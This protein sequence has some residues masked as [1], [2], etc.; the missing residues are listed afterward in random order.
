MARE[1]RQRKPQVKHAPEAR[2]R[3]TASLVTSKNKPWQI[4]VVCI[5]LVLVTV[6]SFSGVR[7][8]DFVTLDD[9]T[10]VLQNRHVQQGLNMQSIAWAFTSFDAGNWHPLTWIS[11]MVDWK[12]YGNNPAGH[13]ITNLCLHAANAVLLFL[14]LLYMT[15]YLGRAAMVA[16]LFALHPAHVESVAWIAERKDVLCAFFFLCT[17]LAYA[18]HLRNPSWKR[19][20]LVV[21]G[22]ACALLSKPMAVTLPFTLL[23]LDYWPLRRITFAEETRAQWFISLFKLCREKWLLFIMA[24]VSSVITV[25]AQKSS[26]AV[27]SLEV[28]SMG[29]RICNAA[30]SYWR[31]VWMM[32]WPDQLRAYY[33][34]ESNNTMLAAAV[35]SAVAIILVT[36]IS[37]RLRKERP[38]CLF[39]WLWFLVTLVPVIGIVQVGVQAMAERYTYIPFIG[40]FIAVVW[41]V[42]DAVANSPKIRIATQVLAVALIIVCAIKTDAQVK[43]WKDSA[44][45][46]RHVLEIDPRGAFPNYSL[47]V[48]YENQGKSTEAQEYFERALVYDPNGPQ[49]LSYSAYYMMQTAMRTHDRSKLPLAGQ[50]LEHALQIAPNNPEILTAMALW[51][52]LMGRPQDEEAYSRKAIAANPDFIS[53]RL[54]LADALRGQDKLDEAVQVYRQ[55]LA[56]D[57][58]NIDAHNN[59]GMIYTGQ[60]LTDDALKEFRLSLA[61]KPNQALPHSKIGRILAEKHQFPEAVNEFT[62]ALRLDQ[63]NPHAHND[64][65][66]AL[67][68]MGDYEKAAEQ[69]SAAVRIDPSYANARQNLAFALSRMKNGD[70]ESL[71]K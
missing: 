32:I 37:W 23:L 28:F 39:G 64:L 29:E 71:R 6:F 16:F 41:L 42:G 5:V 43:I 67:I 51:S 69:F 68:Q 57:P 22:F 62:Q 25:L 26:G 55:A 7:L 14:L 19:F 12:I 40:L 60:G 70:A 31:Y 44:T 8:N 3:M 35:L 4:G 47:G 10:Y 11:H 61:I 59:L 1:S 52:D 18:W 56:L 66:V 38:Y 48:V 2:T 30:I 9:Y 49:S 36:A 63:A 58:D 17:L 24:A 21:F 20:A 65:G 45:L 46:F 34:H 13:H 54:Y 27:G 15:G 50:R 33:F 53:A